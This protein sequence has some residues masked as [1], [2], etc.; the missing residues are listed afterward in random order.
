MNVSALE[1]KSNQYCNRCF[2]ER[3]ATIPGRKEN[4]NIFCFMGEEI[5]LSN[6][7]T[8]KRAKR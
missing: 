5:L 4:S 2:N 3:V 6:S 8:P 7:P 1:Y